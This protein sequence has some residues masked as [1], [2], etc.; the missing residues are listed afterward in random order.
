M[1][2][3]LVEKEYKLFF[4]YLIPA[5]TGTVAIGLLIFI[6]T[7][8]VGRGIGAKGLAA[9]NVV[10]PAF[11]FYSCVGYLLGMGGAT[12]AAIDEGRGN[13]QNKNRIFTTCM[14]LGVIITIALVV[15][16]NLF[17]DSMAKM[18][19]ATGEILPLAKEYLKVIA[20]GAGLYLIPHVLNA[21]IRN[22]KNPT[23][24][25]IGMILCGVTNLVLDYIF[26][27]IFGWG[28]FGAAVATCT[29]QFVYM[30]VLFTHFLKKDKTLKFV[31]PDIKFVDI[32]RVLNTGLP[33]FVN[34]LSSGITIFLFNICLF[35]LAGNLSVAAYSIIL[36]INFLVYLFYMG[37]AQALQ[38]LVSYNFGSGRID[39]MKKFLKLGLITNVIFAV[40]VLL[41]LIFHSEAV[42]SLFNKDNVT[43][44]VLTSENILKFFSA[45]IFMGINIVLATYFQAREKGKASTYIMLSRALVLVV[46]GVYIL[47][48]FFG[49]DGIWFTILFAETIT[50]IG[51][52]IWLK[53]Y[54]YKFE[55]SHN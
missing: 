12:I 38:P 16:Q 10:I 50:F 3:L 46:I 48:K 41:T 51:I 27:F 44:R 49:V 18:L 42:I 36:N 28:M 9:L 45:T 39:R 32:K 24:T 30:M 5:V 55:T 47:P 22:D 4:K 52:L 53:K 20:N 35:R 13:S 19:G 21:F 23:L 43:L 7:V 33:S 2:E 1:E 11:T 29:A 17:L 15:I 6:D 14:I 34:E 40:L 25:M 26:I 31:K 8:F 37:V 54:K